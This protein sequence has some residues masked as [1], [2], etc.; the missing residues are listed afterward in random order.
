[1]NTFRVHQLDY[2]ELFVPNRHEAVGWYRQVLGLE[3]LS[4]YEE[5]DTGLMML[6]GQLH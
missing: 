6:R 2:V 1:V 3:I 4:E 5:T